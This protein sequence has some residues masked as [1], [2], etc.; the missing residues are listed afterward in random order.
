MLESVKKWL[1]LQQTPT[2]FDDELK[3][4][5]AAAKKDLDRRGVRK[6]DETDPLIQQAIKLYCKAH[7]GYSADQERYQRAYDAHADG[8]A[9]CGDYD[10]GAAE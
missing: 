4:L 3:G 2:T 1:R 9:L 7:F 8:L 5:I 6:V 10:K